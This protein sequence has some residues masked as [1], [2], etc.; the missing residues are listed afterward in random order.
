MEKNTYSCKKC[1]MSL[2]STCS[3]CDRVVDVKQLS[4]GCLV[5]ITKCADCANTPVIKDICNHA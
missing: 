4:G 1:G 3:K 2:T 5:Q